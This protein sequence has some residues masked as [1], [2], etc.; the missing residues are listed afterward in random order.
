MSGTPLAAALWGWLLSLIAHVLEIAI[1]AVASGISTVS[2]FS[3]LEG[4]FSGSIADYLLFLFAAFVTGFGNIVPLGH[5]RH[6]RMEAL[7]ALS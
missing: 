6:W 1:F 3:Y 7:T 2:E 4:S 5:L